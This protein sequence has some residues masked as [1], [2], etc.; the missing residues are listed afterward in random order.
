MSPTITLELPY[1]PSVNHYW[2]YVRVGR[3]TRV[4]LSRQA[5]AYRDAVEARCIVVPFEQRCLI[6]PLRVVVTL[7]PP[8]RRKR[9][10]DNTLKAILDAMQHGHLFCDDGQITDLRVIRDDIVRGGRADVRITELKA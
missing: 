1:P 8:D 2:R 7:H 6:G 9:D 5:H 3:A 4:I 10:V